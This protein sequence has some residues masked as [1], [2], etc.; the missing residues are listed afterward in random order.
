MVNG[1][2]GVDTLDQAL[3]TVNQTA[4]IY[5]DSKY[6]SRGINEWLSDWIARGWQ[7]ASKKSVANREHHFGLSS[8][9]GRTSF[10]VLA[11]LPIRN[12]P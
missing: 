4:T 5:T 2:R 3:K 7:T 9:L 12:N 1:L 11:L 8:V 10:S 6:V